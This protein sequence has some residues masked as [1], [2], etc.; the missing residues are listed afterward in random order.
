MQSS[1]HTN[2]KLRFTVRLVRGDK[3][4]I[5]EIKSARMTIKEGAI[6]VSILDEKQRQEIIGSLAGDQGPNAN[7]VDTCMLEIG[8]GED[9]ASSLDLK[10]ANT[11]HRRSRKE[12]HLTRREKEILQRIAQAKTNDEIARELYI[13]KRT[14]DTHRQNVMSKL[15]VHNT[16][17]LLKAAFELGLTGILIS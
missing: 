4:T 8:I 9:Q 6:E 12:Y 7:G 5:H 2:P 15:D 16:A 11:T 17:A 13:S 1:G 10:N 14:V 3:T